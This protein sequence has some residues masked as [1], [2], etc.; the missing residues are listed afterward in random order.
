MP[1]RVPRLMMATTETTVEVLGTLVSRGNKSKGGHEILKKIQ[2]L[3]FPD[4]DVIYDGSIR[5]MFAPFPDM[6]GGKL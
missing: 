4:V 3:S 1:R 5:K 2:E 6:W